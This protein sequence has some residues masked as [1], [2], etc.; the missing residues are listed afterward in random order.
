MGFAAAVLFRMVL[1]VE[2]VQ[3]SVE[4]RR[5]HNAHRGNE[6]Q[7]AEQGVTACEKFPRVCLQ[8]RQRSHPRQNHRCIHESIEPAQL[9]QEVIP[10]HS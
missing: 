5:E 1:K 4:H 9:F 7:T 2:F 10:R 3:E 8:R 6:S